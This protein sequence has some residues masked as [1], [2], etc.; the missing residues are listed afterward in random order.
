MKFIM[1]SQHKRKLHL[2]FD[3]IN[4]IKPKWQSPELK[5]DQY[6]FSNCCLNLA[7]N[8]SQP[9][10]KLSKLSANCLLWLPLQAKDELNETD[11]KKVAAVK[12]LR[13][14]I[15]EKAEGGDDLAK[16]VQDTFG[17]KPDSL[18]VRFIRA[19]KYDVPRA[20]ELMKGGSAKRQNWMYWQ[21][22]STN[23][24]SFRVS[25]EYLSASGWKQPFK[26]HL[27]HHRTIKSRLI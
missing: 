3:S 9:H 6:R 16:G 2:L 15:K 27:N 17:E 22:F 20:F 11:E 18:L 14:I 13:G 1:S 26:Y 10:P 4:C 5:N 23:L 19:R 7:P 25:I 21:P 24:Q 12:E 8:A